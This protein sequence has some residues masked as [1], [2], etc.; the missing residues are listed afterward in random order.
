LSLSKEKKRTSS[1]TYE[2]ILRSTTS[3]YL[4]L[5]WASG[6]FK[7]LSSLDTLYFLKP[8]Y[9]NYFCADTC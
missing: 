4:T 6:I 1:M 2:C 7:I 5:F 8:V 3:Q 9:N